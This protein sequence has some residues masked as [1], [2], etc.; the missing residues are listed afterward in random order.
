MQHEFSV[1]GMS[2]QHCVKAIERAVRA[3]DAQAR[4]EV[5]LAQQRVRVA[6]EQPRAALAQAIRAEGYTVV[7]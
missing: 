4:V 6:S 3:L 2:C 7:E 5:D 1:Q